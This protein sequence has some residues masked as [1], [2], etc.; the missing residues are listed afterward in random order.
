[1][2]KP[3]VAI[4]KAEGTN[5]HEETKEAFE[6]TGAKAQI[7]LMSEILKTPKLLQ[8][9]QILDFPGGFSYGD[10]LYSGKIWANEINAYLREEIDRFLKK[11]NIIIG[12][13]NGFQVLVRSG[14]LPGFGNNNETIGL[15][16]NQNDKF[17]CR[18]IRIRSQKNRC[19]FLNENIE[20]IPITVEHGEGRFI[21]KDEQVL[22]TLIKNGQIV[23]QYI[24]KTKN[25]TMEY[26]D[27]PNGSTFSIAGICDTTG[28]VLGMMPHPEH[29]MFK[30]QQPNW[31]RND[32]KPFALTIY[33]Q[34]VTYFN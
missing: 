20:D 10:D 9:F 31:R 22:N 13:C 18:W 14:I 5:F 3:K 16:K 29:N 24:D 27:N 7:I 8:K 15:I 21:V 2:T 33:K 34:A 6:K 19:V 25:P 28:Q 32:L 17:E 12:V 23:F 30:Y 4:L 26:P 11:G 1:M